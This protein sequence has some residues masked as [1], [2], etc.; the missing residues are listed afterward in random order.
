ML[1]VYHNHNTNLQL[2]NWYL[3]SSNS[4][5][6]SQADS[7][8]EQGISW[9]SLKTLLDNE[10]RTKEALVEPSTSKFSGSPPRQKCRKKTSGRATDT[11][12]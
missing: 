6:Y 10:K 8:Q 11:A 2:L 1:G 12:A 9:R 3:K 5:K 4:L 7:W